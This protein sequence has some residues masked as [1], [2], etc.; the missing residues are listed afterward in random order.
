MNQYYS[1]YLGLFYK[2]GPKVS[3]RQREYEAEKK[4]EMEIEE[5]TID[6][7]SNR[8]EMQPEREHNPEKQVKGRLCK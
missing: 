2:C 5:K 6:I 8:R 3:A 1:V 7:F 4:R